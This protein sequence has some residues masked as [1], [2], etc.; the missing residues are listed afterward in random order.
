MKRLHL[1]LAALL[2][3]AQPLVAE[4][5]ERVETSVGADVVSSYIWRGQK[6]G[7]AA[8]QPAL[9]VSWRGLSLGAWGSYGITNPDDNK[10]LDFTLSYAAKGLTVGV[11]DYFIGQDASDYFRYP[12]HETLHVWEAFLGY[13]FGVCSLTWFTNF[14]GADGVNKDGDRAYSSYVEV[15]AP[16]R[17]GGL[18][19][20]ATLGIVP[21]AT[22]SYA[23]A[24]GFC[25]TNVTVRASKEIRIT[26]SFSLPLF[27]AL[28]ANPSSEKMYFTAGVS[29]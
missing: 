11:T 1:G 10:E 26:P 28:T 7:D 3:A 12:A 15:S 27:A 9:A 23:D 2:A 19:W 29:F 18:S 24:G 4:A 25:V 8:V 6:M 21:W 16:F 5:Q 13:D 20:A 14:A 22:T 17:L